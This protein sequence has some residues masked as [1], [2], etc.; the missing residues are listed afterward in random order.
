MSRKIEQVNCSLLKLEFT[1]YEIFTLR[2]NGI[3]DTQT[4]SL[5]PR[6]YNKASIQRE[7]YARIFVRRRCLFREVNSF[8]NAK[9]EGNCEFEEQANRE[10][11]RTNIREYFG[12]QMGA[13]YCVYYPLKYRQDPA[14]ANEEK[15]REMQKTLACGSCF[16]HFPRVLKCPSCFITV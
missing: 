4:P 7:K 16:L 9:L 11:S 12:S 10:S 2:I 1:G 8:R 14:R 15:T 13:I 6:I 5:G 3:W